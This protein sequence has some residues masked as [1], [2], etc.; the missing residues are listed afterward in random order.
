MPPVLLI[1]KPVL[2]L[3]V[4]GIF[5]FICFLFWGGRL[6]RR[7]GGWVFGWQRAEAKHP[8]LCV[9]RWCAAAATVTQQRWALHGSAMLPSPGRQRQQ[10]MTD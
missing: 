5:V 8:W 9:D 7:A 6:H 3:K 2:L 4:G 10:H 1:T